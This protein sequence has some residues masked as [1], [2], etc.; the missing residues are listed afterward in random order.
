M[1][2]V[3]HEVGHLLVFGI[4][5]HEMVDHS[6]DVIESGHQAAISHRPSSATQQGAGTLAKESFDLLQVC[7][8]VCFSLAGTGVLEVLSPGSKKVEYVPSHTLCLLI[9]VWLEGRAGIG[10]IQVLHNVIGFSNGA[11]AEC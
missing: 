9:P 4:V 6:S 3:F 5:W 1:L 10:G 8:E 11:V 2:H 7:S